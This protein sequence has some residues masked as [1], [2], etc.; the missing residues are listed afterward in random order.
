L[1]RDERNGRKREAGEKQFRL[2]QSQ[3]EEKGDGDR[4]PAKSEADAQ[5]RD[6]GGPQETRDAAVIPRRYILRDVAAHELPASRRRGVAKHE[7]PDEQERVAS[8]ILGAEQPRGEDLGGKG[9]RRTADTDPHDS[10]ALEADAREP[11]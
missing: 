8:E 7:Q 9:E 2:A 3:G 1:K 6:Q 11:V 4:G 5:H 10:D